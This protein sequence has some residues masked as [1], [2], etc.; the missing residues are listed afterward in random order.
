MQSLSVIASI[1]IYAVVVWVVRRGREISVESEHLTALRLMINTAAVFAPAVAGVAK[2]KLLSKKPEDTLSVRAQRHLIAH[3]I[4]FALSEISALGGVLLVF[5]GGD[6]NEYYG[7][8]IYAFAL[9]LVFFPNYDQWADYASDSRFD[10]VP[11]KD[12]AK[13]S[14]AQ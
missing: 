8:S 13:S 5:M 10:E 7:L 12:P 11:P 4:V 1:F 14:S 3:C 2:K 9:M 6:L